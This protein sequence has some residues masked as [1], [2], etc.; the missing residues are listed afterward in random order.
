M[1]PLHPT[2]S[3]SAV[4]AVVT[5]LHCQSPRVPRAMGYVR[6]EGDLHGEAE[7]L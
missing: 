4:G 2:Q 6:S 1:A 5:L 7:K 3:H